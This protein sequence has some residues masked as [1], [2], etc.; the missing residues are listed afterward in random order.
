MFAK[1]D[2]NGSNAAPLYKELKTTAPGVMGTENIKWNF[3]KFL[4]SKSGAITRYGSTTKP[5][6]LINDIEA[7]LY[8]S[9]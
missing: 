5:Q 7:A 9:I 8:Q 1:I 2:V 6:E 3:T 4:I